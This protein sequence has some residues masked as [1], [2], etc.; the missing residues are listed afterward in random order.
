[1]VA[2]PVEVV[3]SDLA[4]IWVQQ[5]MVGRSERLLPEALKLARAVAKTSDARIAAV[6][7]YGD[8]AGAVD[9]RRVDDRAVGKPE[10]G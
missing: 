4:A 8:A 7:D 9:K 5:E 1:M 3:D 2:G 10:R 6:V